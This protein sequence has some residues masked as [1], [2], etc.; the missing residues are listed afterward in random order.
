MN[1]I[2]R[3]STFQL[4]NSSTRQKQGHQG[5]DPALRQMPIHSD[6]GPFTQTNAHSLRRCPFTQ[7]KAHSLRRRPI[8]SD[9]AHSLRRMPIH[10]D[11]CPFTQ[12]MPIH[13]NECPFTQTNTPTVF[14]NI[15][16]KFVPHFRRSKA[17]TWPNPVN[18][19]RKHGLDGRADEAV[20]F[21]QKIVCLVVTSFCLLN[22]TPRAAQQSSPVHA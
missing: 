3:T 6:E 2:L 12:T 4:L 8:H 7:T 22:I 16:L 9:D 19:S 1:I 18:A 11:E 13:S 20:P 5:S 14:P 10:S 17:Q 21:E 15:T